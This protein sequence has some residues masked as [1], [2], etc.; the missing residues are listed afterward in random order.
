[1]SRFLFKHEKKINILLPIITTVCIFYSGNLGQRI[2]EIYTNYIID[3]NTLNNSFI[4][5][6]INVST[7]NAES[8]QK[9]KSDLNK[10]MERFNGKYEKEEK[11]VKTNELIKR[12]VDRVIYLLMFLMII[13][14]IF[15]PTKKLD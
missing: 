1:M 11:E 6:G 7:N 5:L 12:W 10:Q 13:F 8:F 9:T 15:V 2:S 4:T 3:T 14:N